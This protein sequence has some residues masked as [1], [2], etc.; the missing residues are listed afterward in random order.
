MLVNA[1]GWVQEVQ[2]LRSS[3]DN[4]LDQRAVAMIRQ[5]TYVPARRNGA[6]APVWIRQPV[7]FNV[8]YPR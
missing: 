6:P 8:R 7:A 2:V 1:E 4:A 3:G 5:L